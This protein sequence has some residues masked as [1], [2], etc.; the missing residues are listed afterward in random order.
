MEAPKAVPL[1]T[2]CLFPEFQAAMIERACMLFNPEGV[3][4]KLVAFKEV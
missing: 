3:Q 1:S 4:E 2:P